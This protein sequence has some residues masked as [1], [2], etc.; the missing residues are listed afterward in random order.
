[1]AMLGARDAAVPRKVGPVLWSLSAAAV[2]AKFELVGEAVAAAADTLEP[3]SVVPIP[4]SHSGGC[5]PPFL[6]TPRGSCK[7]E[8]LR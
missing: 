3:C 2:P 7:V 8:S 5:R 4:S 6:Q 1:M